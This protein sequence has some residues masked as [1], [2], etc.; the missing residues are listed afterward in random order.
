MGQLSNNVFGLLHDAVPRKL[1]VIL[2]WIQPSWRL[3]TELHPRR[4]ISL[5]LH[6]A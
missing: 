2:L 6:S 1:H 5:H 3:I 4:L